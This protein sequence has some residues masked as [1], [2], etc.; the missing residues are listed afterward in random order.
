[1]GGGGGGG[2][3]PTRQHSQGVQWS[4]RTSSVTL[5]PTTTYL[6]LSVCVCV[7]G[8]GFCVSKS[9]GHGSF[10]CFKGVK[11]VL[12]FHSKWV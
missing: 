1:M 2:G 12:R 6:S 10:F 3:S 7:G 5:L 9:E 11:W 8:G 4:R